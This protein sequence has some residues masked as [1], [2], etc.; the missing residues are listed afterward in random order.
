MGEYRLSLG[1]VQSG[2]DAQRLA[3]AMARYV[4]SGSVGVSE[5]VMHRYLYPY[6]YRKICDIILNGH[7]K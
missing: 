5:V 4:F 2:N 1:H 6:Q 3:M 7:G